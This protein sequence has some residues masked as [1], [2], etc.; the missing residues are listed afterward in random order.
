MKMGLCMVFI[1]HV[2]F[3]LGALV[4]GVVLR[5]IRLNAD[6][7]AMEVVVSNVVAVVT[8]LVVSAPTAHANIFPA[9]AFVELR[10]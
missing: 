7:T 8:G 4:H 5:H 10:I 9:L 2:N 1:G 6:A 3:L